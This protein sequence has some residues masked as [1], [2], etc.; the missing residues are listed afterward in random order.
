MGEVAQ[1]IIC[2]ISGSFIWSKGLSCV[3][4][5]LRMLCCPH[6]ADNLDSPE[7]QKC[8]VFK[9]CGGLWFLAS[10]GSSGAHAEGAGPGAKASWTHLWLRTGRGRPMWSA[11]EVRKASERTQA[12]QATGKAVWPF[13]PPSTKLGNFYVIF[14]VGHL[15]NNKTSQ[16]KSTIPCC[17][18]DLQSQMHFKY[19]W[20]SYMSVLF[21]VVAC[22]FVFF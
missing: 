15:F 3:Q 17:N 20:K 19:H 18:F 4:K 22:L 9:M 21:W 6:R 14:A 13:F 16:F 10:P 5:C 11:E 1:V 8:L 7:A 12:L 2:V